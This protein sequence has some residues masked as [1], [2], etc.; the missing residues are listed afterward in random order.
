MAPKKKK[1]DDGDP[2]VDQLEVAQEKLAAETER[3]DMVEKELREKIDKLEK[4]LE[5]QTRENAEL[6]A[7]LER[8]NEKELNMFEYL[9]GVVRKRDVE[10]SDLRQESNEVKENLG[11]HRDDLRSKVE[12]MREKELEQR[13]KIRGLESQAD[14]V[15]ELRMANTQLADEKRELTNLLEKTA[16][17]LGEMEERVQGS[18]QLMSLMRVVNDDEQ[19]G[20]APVITGTMHERRDSPLIQAEACAALEGIMARSTKITPR[21]TDPWWIDSIHPILTAMEKFQEPRNATHIQVQTN[22]CDTLWK[23]C[24]QDGNFHDLIL[25]KGGLSLILA[26]MQNHGEDARLQYTACGALRKLLAC[27]KGVHGVGADVPLTPRM[28][29]DDSSSAMAI[30]AADLIVKTMQ[31]H[32]GNAGVVEGCATALTELATRGEQIKV[33]LT[34][35]QAVT[36]LF[37]TMIMH[38]DVLT[39]RDAG[40]KFF[41]VMLDS[42]PAQLQRAQMSEIAGK[43]KATD[44]IAETLEL[45]KANFTDKENVLLGKIIDKATMMTGLMDEDD[46]DNAD[47]D[48]SWIHKKI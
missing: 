11:Q 27:R 16:K 23:L 24:L 29:P 22:A 30:H 10:I 41:L 48:V 47:A 46:D 17:K 43:E 20:L 36:Q 15:H 7:D 14:E 33:A 21:H 34:K 31:V 26:A 6:N 45:R 19:S 39:L 4:E 5:E 12:L 32:S 3:F 25:A 38:R 37:D 8:K 42:R 44:F 18:E 13:K 9:S 2:E 1:K 40:V 35:A 28:K